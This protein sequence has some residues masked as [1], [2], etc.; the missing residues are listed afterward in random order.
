[1]GLVRILGADLQ[2]GSS[3]KGLKNIEIRANA[4]YSL[5]EATDRTDRNGFTFGHQI[6][7]IPKH[8]L[9]GDVSLVYKKVGIYFSGLYT[10]AR[11]ALNENISTNEIPAFYCLDATV[12]YRLALK[13]KQE[14]TVQ[15]SVKNFTNQAYTFVR[16]FVMPGRNYL[17]SI[18]YSFK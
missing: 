2:V 16:Y 18:N 7:Y 6:P 15:A 8:T 4:S 11:F 12:F 1:V 5:Q 13:N 10:S 17:F 9:Q 3:Y 14:F